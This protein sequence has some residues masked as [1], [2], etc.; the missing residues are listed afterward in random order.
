[1][2][3]IISLFYS[4]LSDCITDTASTYSRLGV[5]HLD[6]TPRDSTLP[7]SAS[8][9]PTNAD[10][11]AGVTARA[12]TGAS[13]VEPTGVCGV[14]PVGACGVL[15]TGASGV[16]PEGASGVESAGVSPVEPAGACGVQPAGACES[17]ARGCLWSPAR[18]CEPSRAR[19]C[20]RSLARGCEWSCA[21]GAGGV[22][23]ARVRMGRLDSH[24]P[25]TTRVCATWLLQPSAG[26][27][28]HCSPK[29]IIMHSGVT[30]SLGLNL[31]PTIFALTPNPGPAGKTYWKPLFVEL[32]YHRFAQ[33]GSKEANRTAE[34]MLLVTRQRL[35]KDDS[36]HSLSAA[37]AEFSVLEDSQVQ[38]DF[39]GDYESD[40]EDEDYVPD[41]SDMDT[42]EDEDFTPDESDG[43]DNNHR[44]LKEFEVPSPPVIPQSSFRTVYTVAA[45][46]L[47][48][49]YQQSMMSAQLAKDLPAANKKVVE[50]DVVDD[51]VWMRNISPQEYDTQAFRMHFEKSRLKD[52]FYDF[53]RNGNLIEFQ[54]P[55]LIQS[56]RAH[57]WKL[58]YKQLLCRWI[59]VADH[60]SFEMPPVPKDDPTLKASFVPDFLRY[61]SCKPEMHPWAY[62]P[63]AAFALCS[64]SCFLLNWR[65][66]IM[67]HLCALG[68]T[69]SA[70]WN[71]TALYRGLCRYLVTAKDN[72]AMMDKEEDEV[73]TLL[74]EL[75]PR[76]RTVII[77]TAWQKSVVKE[78][79]AELFAK[80]PCGKTAKKKILEMKAAT[81]LS[82]STRRSKQVLAKDQAEGP[83][84]TQKRNKAKYAKAR[85]DSAAADSESAS[86]E[87]TW[88]TEN[89][90]GKCEDEED[91]S[92]RCIWLKEVKVNK[93]AGKYVDYTIMHAAA[94]D[95][96]KPQSKKKRGKYVRQKYISPEKLGLEYIESRP[97]VFERCGRDIVRFWYHDEEGEHQLVG[98]V[99]FPAFS[100]KIFNILLNNH[101]LV[102]VR[103]IR[104]R[105]AL[106]RWRHISAITPYGSWQPI[107]G[108]K[109]DI[110]G[111]YACHKGDTPDDLRAVMRHALTI[112]LLVLTGKTI[113]QGITE[114]YN[115]LT[116]D[117]ELN[118]L[119]RYGLTG[120]HCRNYLIKENCGPNDFNFAYVRFGIAIRTEP[121]AVWYDIVLDLG[122]LMAL[123]SMALLCP[124]LVQW[125]KAQS[126]RVI[127]LPTTAGMWQGPVHV[128]KLERDMS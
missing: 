30:Q 18:G 73:H 54:N 128:V 90:C 113:F 3:I 41:E 23:P 118:R 27:Q 70:S 57:N 21:R 43:E 105:E 75:D 104:R 77:E 59:P 4:S 96:L 82:S 97:Q 106:S 78:A 17:P 61:W 98:G 44:T 7:G 34:K 32:Q 53:C 47:G 46:I 103:G 55:E 123:R 9:R 100:D 52:I 115:E 63:M 49:F 111:P 124:V 39:A 68:Q 114:Q 20:D 86:E 116:E 64:L 80:A 14:Q 112:D 40:D 22:Q 66:W 121:N 42:E 10:V 12:P 84:R 35:A 56:F 89:R 125:H 94:G 24:C 87:P 95:R 60:V 19:G 79:E 38:F 25:P 91:A 2:F 48:L 69:K 92:K 31:Q 102:Q 8:A 58:A 88:W 107:G 50:K 5:P 117:A 62:D 120:Y 110:Y 99:R 15:S 1:M 6:P 36:I 81:T 65:L 26:L 127:T 72:H 16:A 83:S 33:E 45:N 109:G 108:M 101:R 37:A 51:L 126:Q 93:K 13:P 71:P 29:T 76:L 67:P 85:Q 74:P 11:P 28:T 122:S 119:G